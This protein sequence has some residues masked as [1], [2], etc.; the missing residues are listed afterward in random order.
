MIIVYRYNDLMKYIL[1]LALAFIF[2]THLYSITKKEQKLIYAVENY[3]IETIRTLIEEGVSPSVK[4]AYGKT[5]IH[6]SIKSWTGDV[7]EILLQSKYADV[8][9]RD[10]YAMTPL[11][12]SF[13]TCTSEIAF[14]LIE[15]GA[16][17]NM[18][19][20]E[21][22][23]YLHY[24]ALAGFTDVAEF[25]VEK[26]KIFYPNTLYVNV[27]TKGGKT[28]L[29]Y[30]VYGGN[31]ETVKFLVENG[32]KIDRQN[33]DGKTPEYIGILNGFDDIVYYLEVQ[34]K[35]KDY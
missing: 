4:D 6:Y 14:M 11:H 21:N 20:I 18:L 22:E 34:K 24:A 7:L 28:P 12:Y 19:G 23:T 3:E 27:P 13:K 32:A 9:I 35:I 8:N 30:A 31:I 10:N 25:L 2:T 26:K 33:L 15:Y 17:L 1:S 16:N 29:H 5:A